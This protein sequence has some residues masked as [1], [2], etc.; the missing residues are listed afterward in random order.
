MQPNAHG[1]HADADPRLISEAQRKGRGSISSRTNKPVDQSAESFE[2]T[3]TFGPNATFKFGFTGPPQLD[4]RHACYL[5]LF[6]MRA[7]FYWISYN[8][9]TCRG[10]FWVGAFN[11][12]SAVPRTDWGNVTLTAFASE[13]SNWDFRI[14]GATAD[15]F[16]KIML[17]KSAEQSDIWGWAIEWNK[18]YR[19][20]GFFGDDSAIK[21]H[22]EK[23][24]KTPRRIFK[25]SAN[26]P[27][28]M[29]EDI[30]I[31]PENDLLFG[32]NCKGW[33]EVDEAYEN[34]DPPL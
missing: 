24:P 17:R 26:E 18:Q 8:K 23:L 28:W 34:Q 30:A 13:V 1:E 31:D 14:H 5:A 25:Q 22:L 29:R 20:Y 21:V 6:Q 2:L 15:G 3:G 7:F 19:I 33:T 11:V 16:F 4:E 27:Y 10:H 32:D 9:D 12:I